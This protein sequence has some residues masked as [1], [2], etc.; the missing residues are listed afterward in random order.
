MS[1]HPTS[2]APAPAV[3]VPF[4]LNDSTSITAPESAASFIAE[5]AAAVTRLE[6]ALVLGRTPARLL[7]PDG[8]TVSPVQLR[9][10]VAQHT[11]QAQR[12]IGQIAASYADSQ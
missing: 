7:L 12:L 1:G 3:V 8:A 6:K 2:S 5:L 4:T 9:L 11:A 10:W